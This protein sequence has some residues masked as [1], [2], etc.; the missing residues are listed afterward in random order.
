MQ[1]KRLRVD[2]HKC[3]VDFDIRFHAV[4]GGSSTVLI[5]E[6]GSGKST[7]L[8]TLITIFMSFDSESVEKEIDYNYELEYIYAGSLITIRQ[9]D[10]RY[11]I[12]I[13][14]NEICT[15]VR[16]TILNNLAKLHISIFPSRII[17]FY[18]GA[19][20][21]ARSALRRIDIA[22]ANECRDTLRRYRN[23]L[24]HGAYFE[25]DYP[26]R[27]YIYNSESLTDIYAICILAGQPSYEQN[28]LRD[29]CHLRGID[30]IDFS[31]SCRKLEM[32]FHHE[33]NDDDSLK[34]LINPFV[35]FTDSHFLHMINRGFAYC[36]G[37]RAYYSIP[38][39]E[40]IGLTANAL[41][42]F[43][44]KFQTLL[45]AEFRVYLDTDGGSIQCTDLSE[46]Q[47]Q[48]IKILGML[49]VCKTE[50]C[51]VLMD[52]PDAHMNP[53]WKYDLKSTID[54]SL[55]GAINTQ[56]I[57]ATH[58]PLVINGVEKEFIRIF[59]FN[60]AILNN[61]R[62]YS[63]QV[64]EPQEDTAGLG[65]D[66]LLQSEY[67]GLPTSL[68]KK[69]KQKV[70]DKRD[71]L[72]KKKEGT[73][74]ILERQRLK[75]L[76]EE[77]ESLTFTRNIPT[78]DLYDEYV[79]TMHQFYVNQPQTTLSADDIATRNAKVEEILRELMDR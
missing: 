67:Y 44:E 73:I 30:H 26:W 54:R 31:I 46:G 22:Y 64:I 48:I 27:K 76:T 55:E 65:I 79:A 42:N 69:T 39:P 68:D 52:E 78:D 61:N 35:E 5:G 38:T 58:D 60:Q 7:F 66:G 34:A 41:Y 11:L 71:L 6:N 63:T 75:D 49:G 20:N 32:I 33:I 24:V 16:E 21:H 74:T 45:D 23:T 2:N 59:R 77:I 9:V 25:G 13:N 1:I 17:S 3:L 56:A 62:V 51:L 53:K 4:H 8:D 10:K 19:N 70:N 57:I 50:D 14:H 18:S 72:V 15:G 37:Y 12:L 43:F 29:S 40:H 47:R 28:Y 36:D